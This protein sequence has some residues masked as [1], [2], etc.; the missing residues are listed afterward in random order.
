MLNDM[1]RDLDLREAR[2]KIE[3][4]LADERT[5]V[6]AMLSKALRMSHEIL[7]QEADREVYVEGRSNILE[8]P[9]FWSMEQI[10]ALLQTLE[11]KTKLLKILDKTLEA[12]GMQIFIGSEHGGVSPAWRGAGGIPVRIPMAGRADSLNASVAAAI[13]LFEA[14]R[15][16]R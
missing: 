4:E 7:S 9:E 16:R 1:L 3:T 5:K 15:Q 11:D 10:K 12:E 6:D 2:E 13:M 8:E 14:V